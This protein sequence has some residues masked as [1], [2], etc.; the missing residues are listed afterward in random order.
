M[1]HN[2]MGQGGTSE[3][4]VT[5]SRHTMQ[6]FKPAGAFFVGDCMPFSHDGV[7]HV[8]YLLDENH[9]QGNGG[10]GGHQWAHLSTTDLAHWTH[11][12]LALPMTEPWEGSICTGSVFPHAGLFKAFY[13]VR[14]PDRTQHL[15]L[16]TSRDGITFAKQAGNPFL[17]APAGFRATDCRDPFVFRDEEGRYHMLVT[18]WRSESPLHDHGGCLL[19]FE[20]ADLATWKGP[21]VFLEPGGR[22]GWGGVPECPD[23]FFWKG[24]YYLLFGLDLQTHYRMSR[25]PFGPWTAPAV[26]TLG[27]RME[28]VMKTASFGND[29]RIGAAWVAERRD[30]KDGGDRLWGGNLVLR[31]LVQ[32]ADGTLGTRM[33]PEAELPAVAAIHPS[34]RALTSGALLDGGTLRIEAPQ[35]EEVAALDGLPLRYRLACR[36]TA[37]AGTACF[38]LGLKGAGDFAAKVD[39]TFRPERRT[40]SLATQVAECVEELRRPFDLEVVVHGDIVDVCVAGRRCLVDRL[41]EHVGDRLFLTCVGGNVAFE[42]LSVCRL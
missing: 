31:E 32:N 34:F 18:S 1:R 8:F 19:R 24:W 22:A 38:G 13:A 39:L 14:K 27:T 12:P 6:Y 9:H 11:H 25:S 40:V 3:T 20:S 35:T 42:A 33:P 37:R 28:A 30:G 41:P 29:R 23:L 7:F 10:L 26:D 5:A 15:C 36:V 2:R 4:L 21:S 16:A 17:S